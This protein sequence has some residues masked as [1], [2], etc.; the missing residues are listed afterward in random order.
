MSIAYENN[1]KATA[2]PHFPH[3]N[4]TMTNALKT[5]GWLAVAHCSPR[6]TLRHR[7]SSIETANDS[8]NYLTLKTNSTTDKWP[9][10]Y[11]VYRLETADVNGDGRTEALVGVIKSTVSIR[12]KDADVF[13]F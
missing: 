2:Q 6:E 11:P 10:P 9:L 12:K 13:V 3:P 5:Y 1:A 7:L 4:T 8:L